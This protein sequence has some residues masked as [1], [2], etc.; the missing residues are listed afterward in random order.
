MNQINIHSKKTDQ[1][2]NVLYERLEKEG[3]LTGQPR[4]SSIWQSSAGW[5]AAIAIL[6]LSVATVYFL[7]IRETAVIP[8]L[9]I[10]NNETS[11]TLVTS[12]E[13][14]SMVFLADNAKLEYPVHFAPEKREVSLQ[15]DALFEVSG[16]PEHP[17][18]IEAGKTRIEVLGTAF[19]VKNTQGTTFELS[20]QH[21]NVK[22]TLIESGQV[23]YV[24]AGETVQ[25]LSTGLEVFQTPH[26]NQFVRYRNRV[27]FKDVAL[28]DILRVINQKHP[29]TE[30]IAT[31]SLAARELTVSFDDDS[32]ESIANVFCEAFNLSCTKDHN[33][34]LLSEP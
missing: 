12:L 9:A 30:L 31:P 16:N 6:C 33:T 22:V 7:A 32:P 18:L 27:H 28:A 1:A 21:G 11:T 19:H 26:T 13:D 10:Q 25:L 23:R 34:L 3:L 20:V 8:I 24:A 15:G 2:W 4:G 17:F 14:G 5:A 29:E